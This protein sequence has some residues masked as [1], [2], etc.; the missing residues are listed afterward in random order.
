M[1]RFK[2]FMCQGVRVDVL[3][4]EGE[5]VGADF[6]ETDGVGV[7]FEEGGGWREG[8]AEEG[9]GEG[10]DVFVLLRCRCQYKMLLGVGSR[11]V[12]GISWGAWFL[13]RSRCMLHDEEVE[14]SLKAT[15]HWELDLV[16]TY[17][18]RGQLFVERSSWCR[19]RCEQLL[20]LWRWCRFARHC[21]LCGACRRTAG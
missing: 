19:G 20:A 15:Y 12:A 5:V 3:F 1:L 6:R 14:G 17:C 7:G 21:I 2:V 8:G 4:E 16:F 18:D 13:A 11:G 9:G 10:E